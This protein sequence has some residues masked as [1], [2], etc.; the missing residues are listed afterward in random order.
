MTHT[1]YLSEAQIALML[2][3]LRREQRD[4]PSEIRRTD[5]TEL[6]GHLHDRLARL[7]QLIAELEVV[8]HELAEL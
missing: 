3:L 2:D 8:E 4:L 7:Q 1:V 6:R 5:T